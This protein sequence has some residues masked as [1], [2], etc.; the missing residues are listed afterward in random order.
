MQRI[1]DIIC[2]FRIHLARL[3][4]EAGPFLMAALVFPAGLYIF[5][6]AINGTSAEGRSNIRFL[7]GSIVF[8]LSMTALSWLGYM[9]LENRFTGRLKLFATLPLAPS[10]YVF[11]ILIFALMQA[12]LGTIMLLIVARAFGVRTQP[13]LLLLALIVLVTM[14]CLCGLSVILASRVRSFPEGALLTDALGA[15]M[16]LLAP[17]YYAPEMMPYALRVV[18]EWLPTACAARALQTTLTGGHAI[19]ADLFALA[20]MTVVTLS[21]GFRFMKWR[22]E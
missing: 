3:R 8:S 10:S 14:L 4:A 2:V 20:L 19:G 21:L 22:E 6:N 7:A 5:T 16:V 15:G 11:G 12:A 1:D 17:V 9:M 18:T 13:N